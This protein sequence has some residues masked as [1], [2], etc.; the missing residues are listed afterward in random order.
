M[1]GFVTPLA[2]RR[3]GDKRL[4]FVLTIPIT[5]QMWCIRLLS[6][7]APWSEWSTVGGPKLSRKYSI[8]KNWGNSLAFW[9]LVGIAL[10][11]FVKWSTMTSMWRFPWVVSGKGPIKSIVQNE[12]GSPTSMLRCR[13][14]FAL[15]EFLPCAHT[16][17]FLIY[18]S[19][20]SRMPGH[21]KHS[22]ILSTVLVTPEWPAKGLSW[23][24]LRISSVKVPGWTTTYLGIGLSFSIVQTKRSLR[25]NILP[26]WYHKWHRSG[27]ISCPLSKFWSVLFC[28]FE[29]NQL[30]EYWVLSVGFLLIS[31]QVEGDGGLFAV[32]ILWLN[33]LVHPN[34]V[35][36][37]S[38]NWSNTLRIL[39]LSSGL[40]DGSIAALSS[41]E[42]LLSLTLEQ[43]RN[44]G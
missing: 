30:S 22:G 37:M 5:S 29:G 26:Y 1:C 44:S 33:T 38:E 40:R 23:T 11:H 31:S 19:T 27:T 8:H 32:S 20:H 43:P 2:C 14:L 28:S 17:H 42:S 15:G 6:K 18:E 10:H 34:V 3:S 12:K 41:S 39:A 35:S 25:T 16:E 4:S 21:L 9:S 24:L 13:A 7:L 36:N